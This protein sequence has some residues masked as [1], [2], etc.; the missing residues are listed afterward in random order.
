[1]ESMPESQEK[2]VQVRIAHTG[3]INTLLR[4]TGYYCLQQL[5]ATAHQSPIN[6]N[7]TLNNSTTI[8]RMTTIVRLPMETSNPPLQ[9][10]T[11]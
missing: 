3:I 10:Y 5:K 8:Q 2:E 6:I 4:E 7:R 1:M 9:F 11:I